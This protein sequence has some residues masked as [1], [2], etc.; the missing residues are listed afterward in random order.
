MAIQVFKRTWNTS[1]QTLGRC[2][3]VEYVNTIKEAQD[4][5]AYWESKRSPSQIGRNTH[6]EFREI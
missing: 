5:C 2:Y 3:H 4:V 6:Y 1:T